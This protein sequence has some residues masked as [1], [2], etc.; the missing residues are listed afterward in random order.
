MP[1]QHQKY[2][3]EEYA[4]FMAE[5]KKQKQKDQKAK[6]QEQQQQIPKDKGFSPMEMGMKRDLTSDVELTEQV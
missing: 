1:T 2:V 6:Q 3:E 5:R 4:K